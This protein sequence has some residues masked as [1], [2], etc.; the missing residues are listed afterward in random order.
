MLHIEK[1]E[2][3]VGPV[4]REKLCDKTDFGF[5]CVRKSKSKMKYD[6]QKE[7]F[8]LSQIRTKIQQTITDYNEKWRKKTAARF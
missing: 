2:Q 7:T 8:E 3:T 6:F 4:R 5:D 1:Q